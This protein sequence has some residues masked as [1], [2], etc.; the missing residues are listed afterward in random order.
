MHNGGERKGHTM[1]VGYLPPPPKSSG[2]GM[3]TSEVRLE[4]PCGDGLDAAKARQG[5]WGFACG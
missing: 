2:R 5:N 3:F 1:S 4:R